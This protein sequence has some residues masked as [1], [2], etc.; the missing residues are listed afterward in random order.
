MGD[1]GVVDGLTRR[2]I[3]RIGLGFRCGKLIFSCST[4]FA[5][6]FERVFEVGTDTDQFL[7]FSLR[8]GCVCDLGYLGIHAIDF[9]L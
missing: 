2:L 1:L 3:G 7:A 4:L 5:C 9:I 8:V 6:I